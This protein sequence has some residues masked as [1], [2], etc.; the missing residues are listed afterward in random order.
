MRH[1]K[2]ALYGWDHYRADMAEIKD[3][4]NA[5]I[6]LSARSTTPPTPWSRPDTAYERSER[7]WR[8]ANTDYMNQLL[9]IQD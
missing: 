5:H 2:P 4:L 3:L 1:V 6:S 7:A 9:G 8:K